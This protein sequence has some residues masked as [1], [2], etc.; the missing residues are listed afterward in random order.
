MRATY[1]ACLIYLEVMK[2]IK[3]Y[4]KQKLSRIHYAF[5]PAIPLLPVAHTQI[6]SHH[7]RLSAEN[8]VRKIKQ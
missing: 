8:K 5:L 2:L 6:S 4:E 3:F 7:N 1:T